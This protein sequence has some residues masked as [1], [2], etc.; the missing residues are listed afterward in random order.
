MLAFMAVHYLHI[1]DQ[2]MENTGL[3]EE[4]LALRSQMKQ[5]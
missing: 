4:N 5:L 1:V 2:A 3:K